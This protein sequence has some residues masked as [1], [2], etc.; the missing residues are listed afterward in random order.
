[1]QNAFDI[2]EFKSGQDLTEQNVVSGK[3]PFSSN[4]FW[5]DEMRAYQPLLLMLMPPLY[6]L[7][8]TNRPHSNHVPPGMARIPR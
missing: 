5:N 4:C 3:T 8:I 7:L 1:M 2:Q 6:L